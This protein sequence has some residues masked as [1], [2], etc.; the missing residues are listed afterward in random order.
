MFTYIHIY[1]YT[2]LHIYIYTYIHI[3]IYIYTYKYIYI[4]IYTEIHVYIHTN[5][6]IYIYTYRYIFF[7]IELLI[8]SDT[9]TDKQSL[10]STGAPCQTQVVE[11]PDASTQKRVYQ[12]LFYKKK[13]W[14]VW[15][16]RISLNLGSQKMPGS[17]Q[18][19]RCE[20]LV[21]LN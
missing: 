4:Y 15:S 14:D 2:Y 6:Y 3:Y 20:M 9:H 19:E 21:I 18:P 5:I 17:Y 13:I 16:L 10:V 11:I 12:H 7:W 8:G 1:T